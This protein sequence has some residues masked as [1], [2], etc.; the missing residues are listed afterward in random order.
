MK[1][2]R[3]INPYS[4]VEISSVPEMDDADVL[5]AISRSER[6]FRDY[7]H[8]SFNERSAWLNAASGYLR[9]RI[10][11][12]SELC[13]AE[14]GKLISESRAE[15]EKC[16]WVC[17]FYAERAETMLRGRTEKTD[18]TKSGVAYFPLGPILAVMPWNFPFWQVFRFAAPALM[19]GN[20]ALLKHASNVQGC[21]RAIERI[22]LD[23]GFPEGVFQN[24][25][26]GSGKVEMVI[27]APGV[28][29]VTLTGSEAAGAAVASLAGHQIKKT[30]LELG[31]NNA[32]VVLADADLEA[33]I[34]MAMKARL[35]NC[36]QSC[37]AAKRFI[38]EKGIHERFVNG[39]VARLKDMKHGDP[40]DRST[41]IAPL[42]AERQAVEIEQQV[43]RSVSQGAVLVHGGERQGTFY[44]PAV[45]TGV[46]PGMPVFDEE[47]FGPVFAISIAENIEDALRLSN[48]SD[49]G[50]GM[51]VFTS[52]DQS[53]ERF[54]REAEE[55]AVF[56]NGMVKSDPR[57]PFGGVKRSGYGRELAAEGI[58]E[59]VNV[60]T[61]W[62]A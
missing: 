45:L 51:Q 1:S 54:I 50:L 33:A 13:T 44:L 21:A 16:A 7:R 15:V 9:D 32:F 43:D 34:D 31:G 61:W 20:T 8:T 60:K 2:L 19:A 14:M 28:K 6:V 58:L 55:G 36:G 30:V 56:V 18:A 40:M 4:G 12:L 52:S 41:G 53:A 42:H 26:I 10:D 24:M 49:F 11:T 38:L 17:R 57:L 46:A 35:L 3:S 62:K 59:F 27:R 5:E 39:L 23:A 47:T 37:I 29:A 22:F 25:A 48:L